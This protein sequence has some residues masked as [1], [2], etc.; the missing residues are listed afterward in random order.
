MTSNSTGNGTF[1][2][3]CFNAPPTPRQ[4]AIIALEG[5][6]PDIVPHFELE[7]QLTEEYFGEH[8]ITQ[9]EWEA[10]PSKGEEF[11]I[12]NADLFIKT[13]DRF[14]YSMLL[15]CGFYFPDL[16]TFLEGARILRERDGGRHLLLAHGDST[17]SINDGDGMMALAE[18]I[19]ET[20]EALKDREQKKVAEALEWAR[21]IMTAGLDGFLLGSDYG[22]NQGP[23]LSPAM[24]GE[25]VTPYLAQLIEEYRRMG[26]WTIKHS[27]GDL[28]LILDQIIDCH[29]HALH[30]ID[31]QG[32]MDI[33]DVKAKYGKRV[34][35]IGNVNCGLLQTGTDEEILAS[36]QYAMDNGKPGGGYIFSTSNVIFKGMP[37][38]SYDLMWN[39]Y[40]NNCRYE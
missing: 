19:Y 2:V 8:Y 32:N 15:Y 5:G 16:D 9:A 36:C 29:P 30:S 17:L 14:N 4:R 37:K 23:F 28:R 12:H 20:P 21:K 10:S 27:D 40:R 24:F 11:L 22:F 1:S 31:P 13:A 6:Q 18:A 26:A 7:M 25:F 35:L 38:S 39:W 3:P 33:K 34:C